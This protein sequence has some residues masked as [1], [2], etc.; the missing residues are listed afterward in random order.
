MAT[1]LGQAYVQIMPSAKGIS[2]SISKTLDPEASSAG[3]SAGSLLGGKLIGILGSVIAAAK[4]GEMVTK[5]I[6]S[7]ISEGAALQQSLGG[8]ETLFK[9]NANLVKKYADEAYKTTGLSA[10]AYM[11]SVTGFS[12]SL[13][14]SLGGDTAKAAK[15]ANMA[16][17]DMADN[18][19]KMGTSMES[20]QYAYQG[21]A[22]QNY[23]M[24]DN[25]KLGYG[26]TQEEMK[27][28]LS[29]AQKLTGKKYD[30]SNLSDVYEAIHAIQGKIGIT[31]TTAKEAATTF[32]G[33]FEAM[34]AASKN[35]LGKMALGEDI[36]PSLKAL[37][38]TTSNFVLNNFIPMLTN[39]F[40]GFGSVISL[41]FS[42]LIPKIVGFVQTSGPSLMQ[43]GISFI[44]S[45]VNGFLTAYPAFLTVAGKIF[46]DFVSFVIQSIPGLLQAGATLVLNLIDGI[47]ANL[48]QVATSAVSVISN[49]ISMLQANYPA[50]LKKGFEILS[51][52]V[53]GIIARLP[54]IVIT[55]G[56]LIA[57]LAG[58]IASNLPK[59][60]AL[61]VQLLI[62]FVKGI[63]SVI[64]KINETA[65]N[66]GEKLINAIKSIDL[67]SAGRA[68]MRGFLRGLEDVWGDIQ[69][70]V[71]DIAGWIKD[72]KGPIS[73]DRRLLIPA[74]NAIMQGLHQGLVDKFK[75]V[76]NLVN[77][78]AEEIQSSFGNPQLA[79]DMD[80]NVNNGFERIGTLNKNLS[81]QVTST[82]NYTNGNAALLSAIKNL[83]DRP[84]VVSA[85]FDKNEFARVVAKPIAARQK[86]DEQTEERLRGINRW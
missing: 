80:T 10:N 9:S 26:G 46:T 61:G 57:I 48:P 11:E 69:N 6:S 28:L 54:D 27:R 60:L 81:S 44:I 17:I 85:Q 3:S 68:I 7:S 75:P 55:V 40:K 72:H 14:Q 43:A 13:L 5:A 31:G 58:A 25:L 24:L 62:T 38:D 84:I 15:V 18:S 21:F 83:A 4:I 52:L 59:V 2:G 36:K 8:V 56:K 76:K 64:G 74:G 66:I 67:L 37:F 35:L 32:T 50:I 78:M 42:E 12:A 23:T 49:F 47:L 41:T 34:K 33:S 19:N 73:Y 70:F 16:M 45:F 30:I 39:V 1:N 53:Q 22:K 63:L 20:I 82:D 71:G 65:N 86:F 29:D 51:Y 79:F 77:G